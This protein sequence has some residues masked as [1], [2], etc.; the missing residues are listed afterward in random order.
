[1]EILVVDD[2]PAMLR[3][4]RNFLFELGFTNV[5]LAGSGELGLSVLRRKQID[6]L[7]T[8]WNMPGMK[9]I[10]LLRTIRSDPQLKRI[11][12]LMIT[13]EQER[14]QVL[15]AAQA[16]VN[17]YIVKPFTPATLLAKIETIFKR[18][19]SR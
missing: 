5:N 14:N 15:E 3:T 4:I 7:L 19:Q 17:G 18:L 2:F 13:A 16:G 1:M 11:P 12:V 6:L 8:D 10:D 9:G